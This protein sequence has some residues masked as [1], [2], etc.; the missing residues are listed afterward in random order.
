[1]IPESVLP[2]AVRALPGDAVAGHAPD[3]FRHAILADMKTAA[4]MPAEREYA[5][6][7]MALPCFFPSLFIIISF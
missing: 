7:A 5:G 1:L 4:A 3:V 2:A 6:A